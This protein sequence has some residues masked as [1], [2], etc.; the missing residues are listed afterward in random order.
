[1]C[2]TEKINTKYRSNARGQNDSGTGGKKSII[3][4]RV[5]NLKGNYWGGQREARPVSD[6]LR[7]GGESPNA[8][9]AKKGRKT[10]KKLSFGL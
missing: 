10:D 6:I 5:K 9:A 1:V 2:D 3:A 4:C 8:I 7:T